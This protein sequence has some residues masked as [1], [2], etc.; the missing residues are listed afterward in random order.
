MIQNDHELAV[1]QQR[2]QQLR[3]YRW[4]SY[5][6]YIGLAKRPAWLE[7]GAVL[8]LDGRG[9]GAEQQKSYQRYVEEAVREGLPESPWEQLK[10]QLYLGSQQAWDKLRRTVKA[11]TREQP[12]GRSLRRR[13]G[14]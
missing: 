4:S 11:G 12:L 6:A 7:C 3:S 1:T 13:L 10:G 9:S 5:R 2:I 8:E 14:R